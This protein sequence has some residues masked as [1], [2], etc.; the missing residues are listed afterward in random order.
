[1]LFDLLYWPINPIT[2]DSANPQCAA[3]VLEEG[4]FNF[5]PPPQKFS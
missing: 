5:Q 3:D 2:G 4:R 1:M